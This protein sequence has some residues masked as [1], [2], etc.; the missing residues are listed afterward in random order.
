LCPSFNIVQLVGDR[1][2]ESYNSEK[3]IIDRQT[4]E[5][6]TK[7]LVN[8]IS[9]IDLGRWYL[10][11]YKDG[12]HRYECINTPR[13]YYAVKDNLSSISSI[14]EAIYDRDNNKPLGRELA[15]Y[16]VRFEGI[17]NGDVKSFQLYDL[18]SVKQL[19]EERASDNP[20]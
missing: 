19:F 6:D 15:S 9:K 7:E 12:T 4:K 3:D 5:F 18:D 10:I 14:V 17:V 1:K 11:T 8:N 20:D 13:K 16:N 2:L